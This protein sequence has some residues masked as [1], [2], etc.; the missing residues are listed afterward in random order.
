MSKTTSPAEM[1]KMTPAD[2]R[3]EIDGRRASIARMKIGIAMRSHKDTAQFAREKKD[4]A[5]MLTVLGEIERGMEEKN[6][7]SALKA[8][9][10]VSTVSA[11]ARRSPKGKGKGGSASV[12]H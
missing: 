6:D 2:L 8:A 12:T 9:G 7:N 11:P 1:R 3:K 4:L 5:R 10:K